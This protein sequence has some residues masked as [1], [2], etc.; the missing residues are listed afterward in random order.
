MVYPWLGA[1][2]NWDAKKA[3][4][5]RLYSPLAEVMIFQGSVLLIYYPPFDSPVKVDKADDQAG[6]HRRREGGVR[7]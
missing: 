7:V 1:L 3:P 5:R 6:F 2:D 4:E